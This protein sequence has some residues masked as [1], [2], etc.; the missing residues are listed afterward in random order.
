[1]IDMLEDLKKP[2]VHIKDKERVEA[3]VCDLIKGG[4]EKL[5]VV[6]DFD[7][8]ISRFMYNGKINATCH[9]AIDESPRLP[10][11]FR[12]QLEVLRNK[13]YTIEIDPKRSKEEK[14]PYMIE[15]WTKAHELM[16][17]CNLTREDI[18]TISREAHI[19]LRD[20]CD[21]MF[22]QLDQHNIPILIFSAGLGDVIEETVTHQ[23]CFYDNM[24]IVSNYM[25]FNDQ[26]TL[27]GF[28][29]DLIHI[30]NK[31]E[32]AIH[33]SDYFQK[34]AD[35]HNVILLGDSLGDLRMADGAENGNILKIGFLN[36]KVDALLPDYMEGYDIVLVKDETFDVP[37]G[38]L[39]NLL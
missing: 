4:T 26:G 23:S 20:G 31:N 10:D 35:R 17:Q 19:M 8:T 34:I 15:W 22:Q 28:K 33:K 14:Y 2:S 37:N 39:K 18:K 3:I 38:I 25:D 1:M 13:Y 21:W 29:G 27:V 12:Q 9:N 30:Y 11:E 7:R 24:K 36:D 32:N 6:A 5:Q 16:L